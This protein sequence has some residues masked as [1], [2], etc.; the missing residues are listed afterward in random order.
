MPSDFADAQE[1]SGRLQ[2]ALSHVRNGGRFYPF[3]AACRS[4]R[5]SKIQQVAAELQ[6][7][8]PGKVVTPAPGQLLGPGGCQAGPGQAKSWTPPGTEGYSG[9]GPE[10]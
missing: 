1:A 10:M 8:Q 2:L 3:V 7:L 5:Y 4:A 9:G 6:R